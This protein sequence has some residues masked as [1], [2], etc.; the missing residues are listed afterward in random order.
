MNYAKEYLRQIEKGKIE[1]CEEIRC[2]YKRLV[3]EMD[4]KDKSFPFYFSERH[5]NHA[6]EFIES[7]CKHYQGE[8]AGELVKLE[9]FQKAFIQTLFG[10]LEK[11][12][13]LRRFREYFFEVPRK[14]GKSFLSASIAVY[15]LVADGEEGAE[16]YSAATKLDQAKIIYNASKNIVDQSAELRT[17]VKST[18]EGLSFKMTRS[19]MK[20]LPN[21]SKSLDGLNIHFAALDEIH[22]QRDRNMYDVLRQGMKARKQPL[23]GCITTSGF[24]REGLYDNLHDYSCD[25]AKGIKKDDR[26]LPIIYKLDELEEWMDPTKWIKANPGL[27]TIKSAVQLADDVAR[28]KQDSS[29]L[30]TLLVKDFDMKQ[31]ETSAWLPLETIINE[32]VVDIEYLK[33]SYAIGGC[34]LSSVYDLTC[35]TL[36]I[37]KPN[38]ENIYVLQHYWLPEKRI[39]D[40]EKSAAPEAPYK[41]WAEQGWMTINEGAQVNY[42]LV[43]KWFV[44]M[45]NDYDI[46]PLWVCYDR[47]LAGFWQESMKETGFDMVKIAQ[48]PYTWTYPMKMMASSFEEKKVIYQN[49]PILRWCLANTAKKALNKDGIESIQPVKIQQKRRIDGMVSLLNAWVGLTKFEEEYIPYLR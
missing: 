46:R 23:I 43:T 26:L 9:L 33:H 49:N 12:T 25:V 38:D 42:N 8:K 22:E 34:D 18:R 40:I 28:A 10:F 48:G 3:E 24:Y 47:A 32:T 7:F 19:I 30:P 11:K 13:N 37:K 6:I 17:L 31:N 29:Y 14:H 45:V 41:L 39:A 4:C 1:A 16:I 20:P 5:G 27:G 2:V 36:L 21:E 35:A 44:D 15:M